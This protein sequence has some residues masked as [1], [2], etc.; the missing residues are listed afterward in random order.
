M[1]LGCECH[2]HGSTCKIKCGM[3]DRERRVNDTF[4]KG[5][6]SNVIH[7]SSDSIQGC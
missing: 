4:R 1:S 7:C 6:L 5:D 2:R 3:G